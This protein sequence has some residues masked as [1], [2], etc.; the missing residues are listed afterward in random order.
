MGRLLRIIL[1]VLPETYNEIVNRAGGH[2]AG[3]APADLQYLFSCEGFAAMKDEKLQQ[4]QFLLGQGD[5]AGPAA[6]G[7]GFKF[8]AVAPEFVGR[9]KLA[10]PGGL[11]FQAFISPGN[12]GEEPFHPQQ[13][14]FQVE[15]FGKVVVNP[16]GK[17]LDPIAVRGLG[18]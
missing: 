5:L 2:P 16:Q 4:F 13:E 6:G 7:A 9:S 1:E 15:G 17:P 18:R 8:D 12:P 14:L 3:I 10:G 11:V